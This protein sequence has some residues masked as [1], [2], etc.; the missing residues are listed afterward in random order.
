ML[1]QDV[2]NGHTHVMSASE[3]F[4]SHEFGTWTGK[5]RIMTF[6]EAREYNDIIA[7]RDYDWLWTLTPWSS[8][9]RGWNKAMAVVSPS[10]LVISNCYNRGSDACPFCSI[11]GRK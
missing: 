9:E 4:K 5:V 10:G 1:K 2:E 3:I 8:S 7:E 6:D 11:S